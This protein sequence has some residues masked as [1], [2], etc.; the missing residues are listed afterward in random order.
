MFKF[1]RNSSYMMPAHFGPRPVGK[2]TGWYRDVTA[3]AVSYL[4]DRQKLAA[5][6]PAPFE[7]GEGMAQLASTPMSSS[8]AAF[9][10]SRF[11]TSP[12]VA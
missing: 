8:A 11:N 6:L 10:G 4:T 3:M 12:H 9:S 5:R 2:A 1:E 7:V